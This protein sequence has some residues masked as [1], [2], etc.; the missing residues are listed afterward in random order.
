[1]TYDLKIT[2]GTIVDG[3]RVPRYKADIGI[4]NGKI[5]KIGRLKSSDA[6]KVLD[7]AVKAGANQS[8][9]IDWSLKD[10][11]APQAQAA[12]KALQRAATRVEE[13]IGG[14]DCGT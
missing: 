1:M 14:T 2:G 8:G 6:A 7:I 10:E 4:K 11:N 9:A 13:A 3:T 5:A 12:G